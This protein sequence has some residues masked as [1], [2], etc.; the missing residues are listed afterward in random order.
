MAKFTAA[1]IKTQIKK[2]QSSIGKEKARFRDHNFTEAT[3]KD[4]EKKLKR[5]KSPMITFQG[6]SGSAPAGGSINYNVG[7]WN[8]DPTQA[9]WL[10]A[11]VWI[12]SGNVDPVTG[13]FLLNV[14]TRFA[15]LTEPAFAGA[16]IAPSSSLTLSFTMPVPA[17][18]QKTNYLGNTCLMQFNWHDVG[19]YLDRS[20]WPFTVT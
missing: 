9:I 17:G 12:G 15:R 6:W 19:T 14:D 4:L 8:P 7:I 13:T 10:F 2:I 20:V 5:V 18:V 1:Q 11:H 3:A 16:S